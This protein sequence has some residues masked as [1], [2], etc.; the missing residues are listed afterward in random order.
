M[1]PQHTKYIQ[2]RKI[3]V[4]HSKRKIKQNRVNWV[5]S[6]HHDQGKKDCSVKYC[7][8]KSNDE[9]VHCETVRAGELRQ[10]RQST[11]I[12]NSIGLFEGHHG[13]VKQKHSE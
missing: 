11:G 10:R 12:R 1:S 8:A 13:S 7:L 4:I 3:L 2:M 6:G 5:C 9:L